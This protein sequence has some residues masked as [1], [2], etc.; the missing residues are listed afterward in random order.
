MLKLPPPIRPPFAALTLCG[1]TRRN[2]VTIM[3]SNSAD[4]KRLIVVNKLIA[5]RNSQ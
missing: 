5:T 4:K 3:G 1:R 2:P